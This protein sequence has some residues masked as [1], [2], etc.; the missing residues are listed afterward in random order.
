MDPL[1]FPIGTFQRPSII[2]ARDR[3]RWMRSV[4]QFPQQLQHTVAGIDEA[5]LNTCYRPGGWTIRQVIHHCAD[6]HMN[7]FIRMKLALTEINP[8]IK[9]YQEANWAEL[10]DSIDYPIEPSL[11][12]LNA[13]H[14]RWVALLE[15]L[16][17]AQWQMTYYHPG[18]HHE[19]TLEEHVGIYAWHGEHHLAH[20]QSAIH[21]SA[22]I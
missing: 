9:P 16:S 20:I 12:L 18:N 10:A 13:L 7:S 19:V 21:N 4:Q 22:I 17:E 8:S 2:Q 14:T 11:I 6:S 3:F 1:R 5:T 15:S